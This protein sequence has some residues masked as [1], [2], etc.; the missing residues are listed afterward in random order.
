MGFLCNDGGSGGFSDCSDGGGGGD[1]C[2]GGDDCGGGGDGDGDC[3][4]SPEMDSNS[5]ALGAGAGCNSDAFGTG[6]ADHG[7]GAADQ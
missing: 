3:V 4:S 2:G 1:G 7:G 5:G 6:A